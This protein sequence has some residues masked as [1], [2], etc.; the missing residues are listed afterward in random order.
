MKEGYSF[1]SF[2]AIVGCGRKTLYDWIEKHEDFDVAYEEGKAKALYWFE[3]LLK[4]GL[5]GAKIEVNGE[6]VKIDKT[7]LIFS[8]KTRFHKIYGE[9]Q[10]EEESSGS[11]SINIDKEDN[12][13]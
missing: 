7:L 10:K 9:K 1:S 13:L 8:L 11:I 4:A 2:G 6:Q 12:E 5:V 3:G